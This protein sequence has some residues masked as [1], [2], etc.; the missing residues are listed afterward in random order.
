MTH[1]AMHR[2]VLRGAT[3]DPTH[4]ASHNPTHDAMCDP[5][6]GPHARCRVVFSLDAVQGVDP[7]HKYHQPVVDSHEYGWRAPTATNGRPRLEMFGVAHYGRKD[8]TWN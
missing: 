6:H 2:V 4:G 5:T 7:H 1:R 8:L 3:H